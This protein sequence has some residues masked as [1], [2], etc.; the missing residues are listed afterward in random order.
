[1][2]V[3]ETF[4]VNFQHPRGFTSR[5]FPAFPELLQ[6][7]NHQGRLVGWDGMEEADSW[8]CQGELG[9]PLLFPKELLCSE[10]HVGSGNILADQG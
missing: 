1:M 5:S 4:P 7:W 3:P 9:H 8:I 6:S 10:F 2:F